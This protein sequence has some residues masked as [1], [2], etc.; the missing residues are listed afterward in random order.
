MLDCWR[1]FR[2]RRRIQ[3]H[4]SDFQLIGLIAQPLSYL[5]TEMVILRPQIPG[6]LPQ[7]TLLRN[8]RIITGKAPI[9]NSAQR[10]VTSFVRYARTKQTSETTHNQSEAFAALLTVIRPNRLRMPP[11]SSS[12]LPHSSGER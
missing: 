2:G 9:P 3:Q 11:H 4:L 7:E 12:T 8:Q 1:R 10:N 5:T 6:L